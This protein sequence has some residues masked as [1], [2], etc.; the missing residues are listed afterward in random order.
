ML[1]C[2]TPNS[3][4]MSFSVIRY[5]FQSVSLRMSSN[6]LTLNPSKTEFIVFGTPQQLQKLSDPDLKLSSDVT[7]K[8][9]TSVR[10]LGVIL[11]KHLTFYDILL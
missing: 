8:P 3:N 11:D 4:F 6:F 2:F 5:T 10:N 7:I 1:T 9:A